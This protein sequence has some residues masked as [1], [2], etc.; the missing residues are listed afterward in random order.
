MPQNSNPVPTYTVGQSTKAI[1]YPNMRSIS[2]ALNITDDEDIDIG[3]E[4]N[5]YLYSS[6]DVEEVFPTVLYR[7]LLL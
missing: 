3:P 1:L 4:N 2:G 5:L 7:F 6:D